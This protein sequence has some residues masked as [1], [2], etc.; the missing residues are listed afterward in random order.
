M[1]EALRQFKADVFQALAHP[2]RLAIVEQLREGELSAG[3]LMERLGL[4]Q[5][6][7]SQHLAVLRAKRVLMNRKVGNQ[8]FYSVRDPLIGQVLDTMKQYF[9]QQLSEGKALL[10]EIKAEIKGEIKAEGA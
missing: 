9:F 5:A 2:T 4:E 10:D 8:V 6:N 1:Q 7:A 3:T